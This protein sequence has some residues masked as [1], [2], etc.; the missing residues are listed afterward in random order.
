MT[1]NKEIACAA[2]QKRKAVGSVGAG[3]SKVENSVAKHS[4]GV[5][6]MTSGSISSKEVNRKRI[7]TSDGE[8]DCNGKR[9]RLDKFKGS[10]SVIPA[11]RIE[12]GGEGRLGTYER[13]RLE[14][15]GRCW[16]HTSTSTN[17]PPPCLV[18]KRA[19]TIGFRVQEAT[20]STAEVA[21]H[22][23]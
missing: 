10:G 2:F 23:D 6:A 18:C 1:S 15:C 12:L 21:E 7:R 17:G 13:L 16:G 4:N 5:S 20:R 14:N 19:Q 3:E 9:I 8:G 22:G 11:T